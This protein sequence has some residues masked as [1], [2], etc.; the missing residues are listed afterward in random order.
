MASDW[1]GQVSVKVTKAKVGY[2]VTGGNSDGTGFVEIS[3]DASLSRLRGTEEVRQ[4][5]R[6]S[7]TIR[8]NSAAQV[9]ARATVWPRLFD[10][11][12]ADDDVIGIILKADEYEHRRAEVFVS[13]SQFDGLRNNLS[14][15]TAITLYCRESAQ[16]ESDLIVSV[17]F[18]QR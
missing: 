10:E 11:I 8:G 18:S 15:S 14:T 6:L 5:F 1:S 12:T 3:G 4:D 17:H 7:L 9:K 16:S 2:V 13:A